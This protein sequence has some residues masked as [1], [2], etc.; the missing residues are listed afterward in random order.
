MKNLQMEIAALESRLDHYETEFDH[1]N[2]LLKKC[3]FPK[4][5]ETLK[6]SA[7]ELLEEDLLQNNVIKSREL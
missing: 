1:L 7:Y 5:I 4:G 3:G 2:V 6:A